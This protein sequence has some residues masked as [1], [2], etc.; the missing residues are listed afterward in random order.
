MTARAAEL[1][2]SNTFAELAKRQ[3]FDAS[4]CKAVNVAGPNPQAG[5]QSLVA[6]TQT[7]S[8]AACSFSISQALT[9]STT[10]TAT[11]DQ[12]VTN[13]VGA[14][15]SF[16]VGVNLIAEADT[17]VGASYSFAKTI[18]ESTST[19]VSNGTTT[20]VTNTIGQALGTTAFV[21]F[22]P[23]YLCWFPQI[24]CGAGPSPPFTFCQPQMTP[25]GH[26]LLG[27]YTVVYT[28]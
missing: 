21:T 20:T 27:D 22:T 28:D 6:T 11:S 13:T 16:T 18:G 24:D 9:T 7:C 10:L 17:T 1:V 12:S 19:A 26:T 8:T 25:D 3:N 14:S 15:I 2:A 4:G 23:T 5:R